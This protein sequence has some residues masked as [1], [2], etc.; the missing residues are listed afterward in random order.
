M[1]EDL[2]D[3]TL[4]EK[5]GRAKRMMLWFG[6]VSLIMSFAGW[7]SAY[8]VSSS[9]DDWMTDYTLPTPF[10]VSTA[11]ILLSSVTYWLA[12]RAVSENQQ[13]RG[14]S[15]LLITLLAAF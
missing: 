15:W 14:T 6:I 2:T 1:S 13:K 8:I 7:T 10:W 12:K 3:G 4:V 9:R 11:L 5:T